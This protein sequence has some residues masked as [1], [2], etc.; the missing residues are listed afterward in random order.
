M[1]ID[2]VESRV[3]KLEA[4]LSDLQLKYDLLV[5]QLKRNANKDRNGLSEG[6]SFLRSYGKGNGGPG[7]S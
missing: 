2:W 7:W 1:R 3:E 6:E 4:D 5:N